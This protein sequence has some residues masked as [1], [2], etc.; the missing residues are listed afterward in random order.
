MPPARVCAALATAV[1]VAGLSVASRRSPSPRG[2]VSYLRLAPAPGAAPPVVALEGAPPEWRWMGVHGDQRPSL[3]LTGPARLA[4]EA[5]VPAEG[6]LDFGVVVRP[7][8]A[9]ARVRVA[10]SSGGARHLVH[11]EVWLAQR[12]WQDRKL[13]LA[14]FQ[15][16]TARIELEVAGEP[17]TVALGFPEVVG[18]DDDDR[19]NVLVY[20][21]DCLR[22]DHVGAYGYARGTTPS[23]DHVAAEGVLF[24]RAYSCAA[25]TKPSV[26]CLFT[27]AYPSRHGAR[28]LD[29]SLAGDVTTL[30]E[31]FQAAGY[32]THAWVAN[33][34]VD[35]GR[36][37][38]GRGFGRFVALAQRWAG[39]NVTVAG[40]QADA[41]ALNAALGWVEDNPRRRFFLYLHSLDAHTPYEPRPPFDA[42]FLRPGAS[43]I[44]RD[45]DLYDNEVA[46]N[47]REIGRLLDGLRRLGVYDRTLIAITADH[48]EEFMEHG[49]ARHG[50]SLYDDALH[51]PL[52]V[53]LPGGRPAGRRVSAVASSLD[54]APTL[55]DY[56]GVPRPA[57]FTGS[58]LRA[59][60]SGAAA[61]E[62]RLF[63]EQLGPG[64]AL[65]AVR[66]GR[67]KLVRRLLPEPHELLFDLQR[68]PG[69]RTNLAPAVAP[70]QPLA[71]AL[72]T[73][74][75]EGLDGYHLVLHPGPQGPRRA[76]GE[77]ADGFRDVIRL[78]ARTGDTLDFTPGGSTF[79]YAAFPGGPPR[80]LVLRTRRDGAP[81]RLWL[82]SGEQA[83]R[84]AE[85][86]IGPVAWRPSRVP[87]TVEVGSAAVPTY[88]KGA[89]LGLEGV[90]ARVWYLAPRVAPVELHRELADQLKGLGYVR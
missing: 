85:V 37:G 32:A 7:V 30:A 72:A 60:V 56:A 34:V 86:A 73:F 89:A 65:F 47:D 52:I 87:F 40:G 8:E 26:G 31:A 12:A 41:A 39:K 36:S 25:W 66:E 81:I 51:V 2:L 14:A 28:T 62:R 71:S 50:R 80:H 1:V 77:A 45:R 83:T 13:D 44:E 58:S 74:I 38:F 78:V 35:P 3:V 6:L 21:V 54:L 53:K 76:R 33:P 46:Y 57:S 49:V 59:L 23:I 27:S 4:F 48:G 63:A 67:W 42:A 17:A 69:E 90:A 18:R 19:P 16:R 20:V 79:D 61:P 11:D 55:L 24:E 84:G 43:G 68:D 29:G 75:H 64:H 15:G 5:T 22:A 82:G 88:A 70:P 10:V 9:A